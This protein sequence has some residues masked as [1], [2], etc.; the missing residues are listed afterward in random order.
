M[1]KL[2]YSSRFY[3]L[4]STAVLLPFV[5]IPASISAT[6]LGAI[7][8]FIFGV[9]DLFVPFTLGGVIG[10]YTL[11]V[12]LND[13]ETT[14]EKINE[15]LNDP[16]YREGWL[17]KHFH[18]GIRLMLR[19]LWAAV[20]YMLLILLAAYLIQQLIKQLPDGK[21]LPYRTMVIVTYIGFIFVEMQK[22]SMEDKY[23]KN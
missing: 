2:K 18:Y 6:I 12:W 13:Y 7:F 15:R 22:A 4:V 14:I 11:F 21:T 1:A 19:R 9:K 20:F 23:I 3:G 5:C 17:D 8:V 16:H 10:L